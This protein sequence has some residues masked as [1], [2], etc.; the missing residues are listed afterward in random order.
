[1]HPVSKQRALLVRAHAARTLSLLTSMP[2]GP[3][4]TEEAPESNERVM[5]TPPHAWSVATPNPTT[6]SLKRKS[7][8]VP[9]GAECAPEDASPT[10]AAN[11]SAREGKQSYAQQ[12]PT[13]SRA[14]A[15]ATV[16]GPAPAPANALPSQPISQQVLVAASN[17]GCVHSVNCSFVT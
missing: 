7:D 8:A 12:V 5:A 13:P 10:Q 2:T 14:E 17:T 11:Q 3:K 1:M 6:C 16:A 9:A 4:P 15:A